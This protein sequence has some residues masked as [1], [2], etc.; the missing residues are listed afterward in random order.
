MKVCYWYIS[1]WDRDA[2]VVF[3]N[4]GY[5]DGEKKLN[6]SKADEIN[7]YPI[8]LYHHVTS[9]VSLKGLDILEVGCGRGGGASYIARYLEPK[10]VIGV[11]ICEG[12]IKF[13]K[14]HY[15]VKGLCF[16]HGDALNLPFTNN[17]FDVV[18]N[19]ESSHR[20]VRMNRFLQE[21]HDVLRPGG[22]FLFADFR[23]R[24]AIDSL[25]EQLN[26]SGLRIMK[27]QKI[28]SNVIKALNSDHERKSDLIRKLAPR[29]MRKLAKEFA[30]T[31]ETELYKSFAT[32][33][34]EYL[35]VALQ[36]A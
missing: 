26:D 13:C 35:Y 30:G 1:K 22:Y 11:D 34:R 3:L 18:I 25:R 31:K 14:R 9:A 12:A 6:L 8:Q 23:P 16:S 15:S 10:S 20:Y 4:Y 7:R 32:G 24:N 21:V 36:K 33:K 19:V 5:V 17:S 28:T 29:F 27:E 2:E